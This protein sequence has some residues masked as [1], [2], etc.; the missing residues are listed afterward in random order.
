M[1]AAGDREKLTPCEITVENCEIHN[2]SRVGKCYCFGVTLASVGAVIRNNRFHDGVHSAI[3]F[4]GNDNLIELNEFYD[5][6]READDAASVYSGRDYTTYGNVIRWNFFHDM[7]SDATTGVSVFGT[8]FD[9]NAS[10]MAL[11]GNLYYRMQ[12]AHLSHGGHDIVMENNLIV[13]GTPNSNR[14]VLFGQYRFSYTLSLCCSSS[15]SMA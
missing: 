5:L 2:F 11:Y 8:Y 7:M 1:I 14:S 3:W 13:E 15:T 10:G 6:V 12:S 9:D 4:N